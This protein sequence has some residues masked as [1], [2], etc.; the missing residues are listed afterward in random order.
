MREHNRLAVQ[1]KYLNTH[2][3]NEKLY[4]EARK[5]LV[6]NAGTR[7]AQILS[8]WITFPLHIMYNKWLPI[9]VGTDYTNQPEILSL[10]HRHSNK[11]SDMI[12]PTI[13]NSFATATF[14]FG[15]TLVQGMLK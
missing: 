10:S 4:Q 8:H 7:V 3:A 9:V 5:I 2:W 12:N 6:T 14:K 15:H 11:Y 13:L 1:L